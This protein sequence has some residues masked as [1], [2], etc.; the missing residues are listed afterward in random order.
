MDLTPYYPFAEDIIHFHRTCKQAVFAGGGDEAI[1]REW[2]TWCDRYF[3]LKHR[4]EPRGV[5]GSSSTT[6]A[7]E[8]K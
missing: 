4:D 2:K 8:A 6:W 7:H 5:G 1:Y 3:F